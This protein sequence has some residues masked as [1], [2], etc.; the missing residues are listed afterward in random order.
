MAI[1]TNVPLKTAAFIVTDLTIVF[2]MNSLT[3]SYEFRLLGLA[4][5]LATIQ[6]CT[7]Q[8]FDHI[9]MSFNAVVTC[10]LTEFA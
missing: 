4:L 3:S 6:K 9:Q 7:D 2:L 10:F 8:M 1:I 5:V